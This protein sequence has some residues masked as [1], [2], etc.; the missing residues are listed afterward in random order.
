MILD[1]RDPEHAPTESDKETELL[2]VIREHGLPPPVPQ[3]EIVHNRRFI[4]ARRLRIRRRRSSRSNT[5]ATTTTTASWRSSV[6]AL[7]ATRCS[8]S[9]WLPL[10]RD[11]SRS[12]VG[13]AS[14]LRRD[15]TGS[16]AIRLTVLASVDPSSG[17][18]ITDAKTGKGSGSGEELGD[19]LEEGGAVVGGRR[20]A[21]E[22]GNPPAGSLGRV[23]DRGNRFGIVTD[24]DGERERGRSLTRRGA[25]SS[26]TPCR[27]AADA[28]SSRMSRS[29]TRP[30]TIMWSP[31]SYSASISQSM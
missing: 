6:T 27:R 12:A 11:P 30:T 13:R 5:R 22:H 31:P 24:D 19:E 26:T 16:R 2:A 3:F 9:G 29:S 28:A 25:S 8:S 7:D 10:V 1:E 15:P 21:D 20:V 4:A 18:A 17:E 23:S 14:S